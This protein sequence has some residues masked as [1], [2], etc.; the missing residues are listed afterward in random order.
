M[1]SINKRSTRVL[2][3]FKNLGICLLSVAATEHSPPPSRELKWKKNPSGVALQLFST[4]HFLPG[5]N[6]TDFYLRLPDS[7]Q[8]IALKV[9]QKFCLLKYFL[10]NARFDLSVWT[11]S[12]KKQFF[13]SLAGTA[14]SKI[15]ILRSK[16]KQSQ[17]KDT[18]LSNDNGDQ[19]KLLTSSV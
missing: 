3:N 17:A 5:L 9:G 16:E 8:S 11:G 15:M 10:L 6:L 12:V 1:S 13:L 14:K 7:P 4:R 19:S 2:A 18:F